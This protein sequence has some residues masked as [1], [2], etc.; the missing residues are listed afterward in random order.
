MK[1]KSPLFFMDDE[2]NV[3]SLP[4]DFNCGASC[5]TSEQGL[6]EI[7][8]QAKPAHAAVVSSVEEGRTDA[9]SYHS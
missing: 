2:T 8:D 9:V 6:Q 5:G 7:F 3:I 4:L 1:E